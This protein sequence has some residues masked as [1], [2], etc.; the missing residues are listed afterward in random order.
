MLMRYVE[1]YE[2]YVKIRDTIRTHIELS[3]VSHTIHLFSTKVPVVA[4]TLEVLEHLMAETSAKDFALKQFWIRE[5]L[6]EL[7]MDLN[8]LHGIHLG[9]VPFTDVWQKRYRE[10]VELANA[11][12]RDFEV[13]DR[14]YEGIVVVNDL[15]DE[16]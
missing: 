12:A 6:L 8:D 11:I 7:F 13:N 3:G 2:H 16:V 4:E 9:K 1:E 14:V 15:N 5:K 10:R